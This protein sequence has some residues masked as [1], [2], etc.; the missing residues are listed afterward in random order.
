MRARTKARE[1]A[2]EGT[3][4]HVKAH[5]RVPVRGHTKAR[6]EARWPNVDERRYG[7]PQWPHEVVAKVP[8]GRGLCGGELV[9]FLNIL[10]PC[11]L[12]ACKDARGAKKNAEVL[13]PVD[14]YAWPK[15]WPNSSLTGT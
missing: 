6:E 7:G 8:R 5:T 12:G 10:A 14:E 4:G 3:R 15:T 1:G 9:G 13:Y 2:R 11:P